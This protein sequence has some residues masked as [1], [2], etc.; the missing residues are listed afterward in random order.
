MGFILPLAWSCAIRPE[1]KKQVVGHERVLR[2]GIW[3]REL[4]GGE[5]GVIAGVI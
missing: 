5:E 1:S 4:R 3:E 2:E